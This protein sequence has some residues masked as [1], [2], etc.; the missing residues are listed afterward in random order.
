MDAFFI[1][2][3]P[4]LDVV[5]H[6]MSWIGFATD[7]GLIGTAIVMPRNQPNSFVTILIGWAGTMIGWAM[8]KIYF[9][10][11]DRLPENVK[12]REELLS[13]ATF[14]IG[15]VGTVALLFLYKIIA[16]HTLKQGTEK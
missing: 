9:P 2:P 16:K 8:A 5:N 12:W 4:A 14:L 10:I 13:P 6:V 7:I 1:L 3:E 15:I 11:G